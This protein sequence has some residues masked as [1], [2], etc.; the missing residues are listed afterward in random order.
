MGRPH[1]PD[2]ECCECLEES[3]AIV[4]PRC[5]GKFEHLLGELAVELRSGVRE[6]TL[7]VDELLEVVEG[8]VHLDDANLVVKEDVRA[9]LELD[10]GERAASRCVG[11]KT[12]VASNSNLIAIS[13]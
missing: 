7:D 13:E 2:L 5:V 1:L 9:V 3:G 10:A 8:S 4:A 11:L 6:V 12:D